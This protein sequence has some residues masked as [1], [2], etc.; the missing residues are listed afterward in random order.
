MCFGSRRLHRCRHE[1]HNSRHTERGVLSNTDALVNDD[2]HADFCADVGA[3][4]SEPGPDGC[5]NRRS[6]ATEDADSGTSPHGSPHGSPNGIAHAHANT[7]TN[8]DAIAV[9]DQR[10]VWGTACGLHL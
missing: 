4:D 10:A 1:S 2:A 9:P 3:A 6:H 7:G 8:K 5:P